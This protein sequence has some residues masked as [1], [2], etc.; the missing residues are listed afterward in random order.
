[1][2]DAPRTIDTELRDFARVVRRALLMWVKQYP[3]SDPRR[4]PAQ[5]IIAY[6]E[7]RYG[8]G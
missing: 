2:L 6:V 1:M 7:Q 8:A 4:L 5:M 3:A